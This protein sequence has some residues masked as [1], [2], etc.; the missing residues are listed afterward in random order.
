MSELRPKIVKL[1]KMVGG[2]AGAMTKIDGNAPEYYS[3]DCVVTDDMADIAMIIGLRKPRTVEYIAK[4]SDK[5]QEELTS[6]LDLLAYTGVA[7]V[8]TDKEDKKDR[9]F[10]NMFAP[11]MLEMMVN[12]REQ[13]AAFPQIGKAFEAYTRLRLAP[14]AAKFPQG[15]AMMR[16]IPI[17]ESIKDIPNTQPWE[18]L[19]YYL[20]KYD[21]FSVSDC[22]CRQSRRVIDEGCGHLEKDICVQMGDGA[23]YY[24]RTGRGRKIT[25]EEAKEILKFAEDNGLMHEM[26]HT[27]GLGESAAIC[28]CCS[29][30]CFSLRL[31]TLFNTPDAI[32]SNFTAKVTKEDCVACG[33]CVENCPSNALK[34]GQKLCL[35]TPIPEKE[36]RTARDHVWNES[37]WNVDYRE[38]REDVA[39]EGTSPCKTACPAHI[40]VQGYISL[41]AQGRYHEALELIKKENPFPA[42]CGRICPH[43]CESECTR[44]DIDEPIA[45]DEI[46]KFIADKELD[47]SIRYIPPMRYHLGNKVAVIGSGP[48]GLSCAYYLA[49]DGYEVTVFEKEEIL[50]GMLTLGIP[51]FRLEKEVLNTE[52]DVLREMGVTFKTGIEIGKDITISQLRKDGYEA[53]YLA[54]G[55][56]GGRSLGIEG[57]DGEGVVAGVDFLRNVNLGRKQE[58]SGNVVVI[59]GGNVAIDVART[60]TREGAA[61]VGLYCLESRAEMPALPE[62]LT[63]AQEDKVTFN[64]G[65]G[66]KRILTENG[67]VTGVEFKRCIS[68]F[69]EEHH[70]APKY[71]ESDT[72]IVNADTVLLSIGQ[73]IQ[74]GDL[75][76]ESKVELGRGNTAKADDLTCQTAEPDIFVGGDCCTGP[77]FAIHAIAAGK[78]GAISIHRYVQPGQSLVYG[79]DKREYHAFDKNNVAIGLQDYDR[80]PRQMPGHSPIKKGS[81]L[82]DR[83]TFTEEQLK[84]ETLR[85]LGCGAVEIDSYKC[86]GCGMCTT[87]CKF[88]AIHL[89]RTYNTVPNTY[90]MLPIK[91][92]TN[93]IVR[94]GKIASTLI[95]EGFGGKG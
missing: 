62:E 55:A 39:K 19:S 71:D 48:A 17:E 86:I 5:S 18:H 15:M 78:E 40:S 50:G 1:A 34:L 60:A 23:E 45:I 77:K 87:K 56:Q 21:T 3:L 81:F 27:D 31:A 83:N 52:I 88:D 11:G 54:I 67:K 73:S 69:D 32:R 8:W 30:S 92:A 20:D 10:V 46:K 12:N 89:E 90:E 76:A 9:Y 7:K 66:P 75:L 42:V 14:M 61:T 6:I 22:S 33:Q 82:D 64:N 85:C 65:W 93:A 63:E 57:E 38:N 84:K 74:W 37:N 2:I 24:I 53:F 29:C 28:N 72:I 26:P 43:A 95:K 25:R 70:F 36:E 58:L 51:S 94:T 91:I 49:I 44:G 35:K 68:V 16:V 41:A 13:L 47:G 4:R 59:G 79:R 80:A